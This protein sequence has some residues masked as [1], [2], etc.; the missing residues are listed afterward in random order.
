MTPTA[1]YSL[2]KLDVSE[3]LATITVNRPDALNGMNF[4]VLFQMHRAVQQAI[5]DSHVR[6]IILG[7]EGK[8]FV[9]G[10]D[11]GFFIRNIEAGD[12]ARIVKLTEAGHLLMNTIDASPKPVVVRVQGVALGAGTELALACDRVVAS[13][14]ASFGL[15]ETGLGIYPGFG[16]T[17]RTPRA[18]GVGLAKWL[19]YTGKTISANEARRIHLVHH[20]VPQEV[21][22]VE[23]RRCALGLLA[24]E[25]DELATEHIQLDRFFCSHP[26]D[27]LRT[28][29]LD[30][31]LPPHLRRAVR[32]IAAKAPIALQMVEQLIDRGTQLSLRDG[33]QLEIDYATQI[34]STE[35][36]LRGLSFRANRQV[37]QPCFLGR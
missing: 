23:A 4:A 26:V 22:D 14:M 17:Q 34:F 37:G 18:L 3:G 29:T 1:D 30:E 31:G 9:V 24:W 21:L 10:A 19:M 16:G 36:A 20:V 7:G 25:P 8:A 13:P 6:A 2:L 27:E 32:P 11:L 33:L 28:G 5:A 15:P 12:L 35:D